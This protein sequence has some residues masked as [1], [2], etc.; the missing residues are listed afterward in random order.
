MSTARHEGLYVHY[1]CG[2]CAPAGWINFDVSLRLRLERIAGVGELL[3]LTTGLLFPPDV[4][5]GNIVRGLPVTEKSACGVYCSHVLACLAQEDLV[6]ALRNTLRI[7]RPGG[8]FRLVV[9]D[10]HWRA[11][12][13]V[14]AAANGK[15]FAA[16]QF[17]HTTH[18]GR[19]GWPKGIIAF[20]R[21]YWGHTANLWMYDFASLKAKLEDAGFVKVRRCELGDAHDRM[22]D[23]VEDKGRFFDHGER[24]LAIEAAAPLHRVPNT[25][26]CSEGPSKFQRD[27]SR[28]T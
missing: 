24:E 27:R 6:L 3:R 9:P 8:T 26:H 22:F 16:D 21:D 14:A 17:M 5:F 18:L 19:R 7:L 10:L 15:H 2:I 1:G 28:R 23:L 12:Q 4:Q 25:D 20:T 13:Y 11:L